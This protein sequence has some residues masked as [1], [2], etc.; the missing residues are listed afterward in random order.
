ME[1]IRKALIG[2]ESNRLETGLSTRTSG[3]LW[4]LAEVLGG[5]VSL[6]V[7]WEECRGDGVLVDENIA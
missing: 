1:W 3:S 5:R 4:R 6:L 2:H 7:G